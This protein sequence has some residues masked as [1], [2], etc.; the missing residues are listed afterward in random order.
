MA[1]PF[2]TTKDLIEMLQREDPQGNG[3]PI[4]DGKRITDVNKTIGNMVE[5]SSRS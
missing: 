4:F 5:L 3:W 2:V 1:A